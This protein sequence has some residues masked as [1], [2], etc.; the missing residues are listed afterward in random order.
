MVLQVRCDLRQTI[1]VL[2]QYDEIA[3]CGAEFSSL[4]RNSLNTVP[5]FAGFRNLRA[6]VV[7]VDIATTRL[8]ESPRHLA[9]LAVIR[10]IKVRR[11]GDVSPYSSGSGP[12]D[13][14]HLGTRTRNSTVTLGRVIPV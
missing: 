7:I 12:Y 2:T 13:L 3:E 1:V 11:L 10:S 9:S 5:P 4:G 8:G 6:Q 14:L